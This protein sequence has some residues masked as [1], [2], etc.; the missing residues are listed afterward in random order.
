MIFWLKLVAALA[1]TSVI[2]FT[3]MVV[4]KNTTNFTMEELAVLRCFTGVGIGA[5]ITGWFLKPR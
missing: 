2:N 3:L 1:I 4:F 5:M